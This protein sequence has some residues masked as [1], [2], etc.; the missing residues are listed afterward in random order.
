MAPEENE[1]VI[2][3]LLRRQRDAELVL[4]DD[5][6]LPNRVPAVRAWNQKQFNPETQKCLRLRPSSDIEAFFV[7]SIRKSEHA[8]DADYEIDMEYR[9]PKG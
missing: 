4:L 1:A 7:A 8:P 2:D 3:Y 6:V 5:Y 9:A